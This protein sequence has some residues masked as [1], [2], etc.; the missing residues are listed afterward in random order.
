MTLGHEE[1]AAPDPCPGLPVL[2]IGEWS[3]EKHDL[4][5]RYVH[6]SWPARQNWPHRSFIDLFC[7]PGRVL[8]RKRR[9]ETDGGALVACRQAQTTGGRF[10]QVVIG[11]IDPIAAAA[12]K[13]RLEALQ[14]PVQ[15]LVGPADRTVDEVLAKVKPNGLHL[16]Y[17]DPFNLE[18]LPFS[19]IERLA[20]FK[21]IDVVVHFSIM[22]LQRELELDFERDESR[23]EVFAPGWRFNIDPRTVSKQEAR[24][25]FVQYWLSL[26]NS[27]GFS[28]SR[29]RPLMTNSNNGPLYRMMFLMRHPL[30]EKLWGDIAKPSQGKLF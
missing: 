11:D 4:L 6:A 10:T 29:E 30:A 22:D 2:E 8:V 1:P 15:T 28:C 14:A 19:V 20:R 7:G 16:A 24:N 9:V 25:Q 23:L 26:V 18:H 5:R 27:L 3:L 21:N 17:L 13:A 12:C